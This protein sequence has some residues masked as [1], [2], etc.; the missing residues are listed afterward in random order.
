MAHRILH[1]VPIAH[2]LT[3]S[4]PP[5]PAPDE[6]ERPGRGHGADPPAVEPESL[7]GRCAALHVA[8]ETQVDDAGGRAP[9]LGAPPLP[10]EAVRHLCV[11]GAEG[12][13]LAV[14]AVYKHKHKKND[15]FNTEENYRSSF[16]SFI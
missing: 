10:V 2:R 1:I 4:H 5:T 15:H 14:S 9:G 3:Y 8:V 6:A 7:R 11:P 13:C 12:L 16:H